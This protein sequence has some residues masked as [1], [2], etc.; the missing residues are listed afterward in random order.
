M[1]DGAGVVSFISPCG[2]LSPAG[3]GYFPSPGQLDSEE[4]LADQALI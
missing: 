4:T 1:M 3:I 2:K